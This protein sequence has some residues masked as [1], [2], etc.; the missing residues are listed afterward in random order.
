MTYQTEG[1][2]TLPSHLSTETKE[3]LSRMLVVDPVKRITISEIRQLPWFNVDLPSYLRPFPV[4]PSV[5]DKQFQLTAAPVMDDTLSSHPFL[6]AP[7]TSVQA[8]PDPS[9]VSPDLG[10]IDPYVLEELMGKVEGLS[11]GQVLDMLRAP[12]TNQI[13]VAYHLCQDYHETLAM[14]T[15]LLRELELGE[16]AA[17]S[18]TSLSQSPSTGT[19]GGDI[20]PSRPRVRRASTRPSLLTVGTSPMHY[21]ALIKRSGATTDLTHADDADSRS[22]S[23]RPSTSSR[24]AVDEDLKTRVSELIA[25]VE[26]EALEGSD[27]DDPGLDESDV[28]DDETDASST[29]SD[30]DE[31]YASFDMVDDPMLDDAGETLTLQDSYMRRRVH[32]AVLE[33]SLPAAQRALYP[34]GRAS[35]EQGATA[36]A[37]PRPSVPPTLAPAGQDSGTTS[38]KS[39]SRRARSQWHFGIRSRSHPMEIMLVL[40]RTMEAL[41]MEWCP[42]TPLPPIAR[43]LDQ[44]TTDERQQVLDALNEDIFYAQ[45]QCHLYHHKVRLDLQLYKADANSYLVDFRHV[46]YALMPEADGD[47]TSPPAAGALQ[48]D[49]PNPFLFFDAVFRLIVELAGA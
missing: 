19:E 41:G 21:H 16:E 13:K 7:S 10:V 36:A 5:E 11:R 44:M 15:S 31:E 39:N 49:V 43:G 24:K 37:E 45:T 33:T 29:M 40:Y 2:Y 18:T 12:E 17:S 26:D 38:G 46:G 34:S 9:M 25:S 3:L 23:R 47:T 27:L 4:T 35:G 28:S 30:V 1:I 14:A 42:K 8:T 22:R 32:L 20:A 48:R 6:H